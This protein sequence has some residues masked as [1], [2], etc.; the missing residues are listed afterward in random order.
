MS[1]LQQF[2]EM[3]EAKMAALQKALE[4]EGA[5]I[6]K[7]AVAR[8]VERNV[9]A[10]YTSPA[11]VPYKRRHSDGG[12]SDTR[13][14]V[15]DVSRIDSS[16]LELTLVNNTV[17]N[18]A[19]EPNYY[20]NHIADVIEDGNYYWKNSEIYKTGMRRP[21]MEPA[22]E[23]ALPELQRLVNRILGENE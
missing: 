7:Q 19:E 5:D 20:K 15:T 4:T 6:L 16:T 14:Y 22:A 21:F 12:L 11:A 17:G 23:E 8:S 2:N 13:N 18:S 1:L 9:Y 3:Q 10:Q